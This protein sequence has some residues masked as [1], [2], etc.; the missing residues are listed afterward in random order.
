MV[1][2]FEGTALKNFL[3]IYMNH[4]TSMEIEKLKV[5]E[6]RQALGGRGLDTKGTKPILVQRL[7]VNYL[8]IS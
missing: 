1:W 4:I 3:L 8:L 7:R 6:L 2:S 5:A